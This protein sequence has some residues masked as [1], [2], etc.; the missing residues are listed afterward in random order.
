MIDIDFLSKFNLTN[1]DL[2]ALSCLIELRRSGADGLCRLGNIPS[3]KIYT[4]LEKL[5]ALGLVKVE[6]GRPKIYKVV[7][8]E[9]LITT[10]KELNNIENTKFE[11]DINNLSDYLAGLDELESVN[12]EIN[13][14]FVYSSNEYWDD[15]LPLIQQ[16]KSN[17]C[18]IFSIDDSSSLEKIS[19]YL[20]MIPEKIHHQLIIIVNEFNDM[21][22]LKEI[23]SDIRVV[24][25]SGIPN[26][27]IWDGSN[28]I[29]TIGGGV[30]PI[31]GSIYVKSDEVYSKSWHKF[32]KLWYVGSD[33]KLVHINKT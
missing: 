7:D 16:A 6:P 31:E 3:S 14:T 4:S 26:L 27:H 5:A 12:D 1:Y 24:K 28:V 8:F 22:S 9:S 33:I 10:I 19:E 23:D 13:K 2:K 17:I 20:N 11:S 21:S 32:M 25:Q 30:M 18:S 15:H 29:Y